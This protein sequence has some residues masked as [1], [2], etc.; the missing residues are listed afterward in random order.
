[1]LAEV[2][3]GRTQRGQLHSALMALRYLL[4]IQILRAKNKLVKED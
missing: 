1:M 3:G 2:A 4:E